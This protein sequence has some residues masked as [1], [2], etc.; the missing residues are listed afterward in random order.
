MAAAG[1]LFLL[2]PFPRRTKTAAG[3]HSDFPSFNFFFYN[4]NVLFVK[5]I[6]YIYKYRKVAAKFSGK[7]T[8]NCFPK[9]VFR[10][11]KVGVMEVF[12]FLFW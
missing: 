10:K 5:F 1:H 6:K 8:L 7:S 2:H 3:A 4:E 9:R 11:P 12:L